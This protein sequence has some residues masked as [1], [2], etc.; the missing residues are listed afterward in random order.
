MSNYLLGFPGKMDTLGQPNQFGLSQHTGDNT[1]TSKLSF[2]HHL[3]TYS[4]VPEEVFTEKFPL[5]HF[6]HIPRGTVRLFVRSLLSE[7]W[8]SSLHP[9]ATFP[10][11]TFI[12]RLLRSSGYIYTIIK[13]ERVIYFLE[14]I[15]GQSSSFGDS[16]CSM[17]RVWVIIA[18]GIIACHSHYG[19]EK[20]VVITPKSYIVN[21]PYIRGDVTDAALKMRHIVLLVSLFGFQW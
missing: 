5:A 7:R 21:A 9:D 15:W 10:L 3:G 16:E 18:L 20:L 1:H 14:R 17:I 13:E 6:L 19:S 11:L 2:I 8:G 12:V 4:I